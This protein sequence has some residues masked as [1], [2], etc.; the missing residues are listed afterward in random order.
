MKHRYVA[1]I[2]GRLREGLE[3]YMNCIIVRKTTVVILLM[4]CN[5]NSITRM[6]LCSYHQDSLAGDQA[7]RDFI[8]GVEDVLSINVWKEP[9]LSIREII[10]RP[11]GKISIPLI[12]D[13]RAKGISASQL[14]EN[15]AKSL[16]EFISTPMVTVTVVRI[17]SQTVSVMG[18][19][20]RPGSFALNSSMTV[21]D[22]LARAG[23]VTLDAKTKKIRI[24]RQ[25]NG[26]TIQFLVNYNDIKNGKSLQQ[27][28][29]L[30]NGDVVIVP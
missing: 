17:M 30:Y 21:I 18:E 15:I 1:R 4:V 14:Q 13:V 11:D 2:E 27:N 16:S 24:L 6:G 28:I 12:G 3:V 20:Q 5:L 10:V 7:S 23:G 8:I 22:V 25:D 26:R 29:K 9:D 19:V